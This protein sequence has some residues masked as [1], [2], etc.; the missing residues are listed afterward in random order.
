V[1]FTTP[2]YRGWSLAW[3]DL[4]ALLSVLLYLVVARHRF[5]HDFIMKVANFSLLLS[6]MLFLNSGAVRL[7]CIK[8]ESEP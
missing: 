3:P 7:Y 2:I 6:I 1:P 4:A 8:S 5:V